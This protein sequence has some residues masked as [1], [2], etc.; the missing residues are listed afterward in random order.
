MKFRFL[1]VRDIW[2]TSK[3]PSLLLRYKNE[4]IMV[5]CGPGAFVSLSNKEFKELYKVY[6]THLHVDHTNDLPIIMKLH[7]LWCVRNLKN[8][9]LEIYGPEGTKEFVENIFNSWNYLKKLK[10][11]KYIKVYEVE[12]NKGICDNY[13]QLIHPIR[14]YGYK[15]G[16]L[17]VCG[18][19]E[20]NENSV[21]VE[22]K[23]LIHELSLGLNEEEKGNHT[24]PHN[25]VKYLP[26]CKAKKIFFWHYGKTVIKE[27]NKIKKLF[28]S[29][30]KDI[31]YYLAKP[32][33][34]F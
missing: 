17:Y 31:N 28:K 13:Y 14:S 12:E 34:V 5:D 11:D 6:L 9:P 7:W 2:D 32:N 30:R 27:W 23:I 26:N 10:A 25:F 21:C 24:N 18:D 20:C 29:V 33:L 16:D 15:F 1:G 3:K 19:C 4:L 22:C 8:K